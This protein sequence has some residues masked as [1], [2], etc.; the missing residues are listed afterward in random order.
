MT[1]GGRIFRLQEPATNPLLRPGWAVWPAPVR[2]SAALLLPHRHYLRK[3]RHSITCAA[4]KRVKQEFLFQ[5]L[6]IALPG[7][8]PRAA[9]QKF[10]GNENVELALT[11]W[12]SR[13]SYGNSLQRF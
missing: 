5:G 1:V 11:Y 7:N 4:G 3:Y 6:F 13:N 9:R 12:R 8:N 2:W 10:R